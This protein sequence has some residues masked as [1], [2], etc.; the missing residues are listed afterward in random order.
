M[1]KG[2]DY[3]VRLKVFEV[4]SSVPPK[5]PNGFSWVRREQAG[6]IRV[7]PYVEDVVRY[8]KKYS[9]DGLK[10]N[11]ERLLPYSKPGWF[12]EASSWMRSSLSRHGCKSISTITHMRQSSEGSILRAET[13]RGKFYMKAVLP[14]GLNDEVLVSSS[15]SEVLRDYFAKPVATEERLRWMLM[16]I[17]R[18]H[19]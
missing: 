3:Y 14:G 5:A 6:A 8:L 16:E 18:A 19:V 9:K 15:L 13:E 10:V 12:Q 11:W 4:L 17:G 7:S 2:V 1:E